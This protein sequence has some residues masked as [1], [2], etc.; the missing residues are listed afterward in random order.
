MKKQSIQVLVFLIALALSVHSGE[1]VKLALFPFE[2]KGIV[3][4]GSIEGVEERLT[5]IVRSKESFQVMGKSKLDNFFRDNNVHY[6]SSCRQACKDKLG[7]EGVDYILIPKLNKQNNKLSFALDLYSIEKAQVVSSSSA[8]S[9]GEVSG[10]L[11]GVVN[12]LIQN[13]PKLSAGGSKGMSKPAWVAAEVILGGALVTAAIL[14]G[15][16]AST[17]SGTE[18]TP[19]DPNTPSGGDGEETTV[20]TPWVDNVTLE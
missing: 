10:A 7:E 15:G 11:Q 18:V 19:P 17:P 14:L 8:Y 2:T 6:A 20:T 12:D 16:D 1:T 4:G 5:E 13:S 3:D 9:S